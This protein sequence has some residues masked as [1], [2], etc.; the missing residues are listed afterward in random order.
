[1]QIILNS[2]HRFQPRIYLVVRPEGVNHPITDI[3]QERYRTYIFPE[4]IFTA[5]TA[6]QNQL[7]SLKHKLLFTK[8]LN[9]RVTLGP[10]FLISL[11][12]NAPN[13]LVGCVIQKRNMRFI[14]NKITKVYIYFYP[15]DSFL[16]NIVSLS[17]SFVACGDLRGSQ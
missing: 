17:S 4:T 16:Y 7:V 2:M 6:Y 15:T 14:L 3:E 1:M 10:N 8:C 11:L 5:V 9:V 13:H 12:D